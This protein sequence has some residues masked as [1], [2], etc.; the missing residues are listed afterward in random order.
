[1]HRAGIGKREK[2]HR[3]KQRAVVGF[4]KR[5]TDRRKMVGAKKQTNGGASF[6]RFPNLVGPRLGDVGQGL[7]TK[8]ARKKKARNC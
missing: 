1:M 8:R 2:T 4:K 6:T 3:K 5:R 7:Q